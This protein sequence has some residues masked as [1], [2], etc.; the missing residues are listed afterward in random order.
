M[1]GRISSA[2]P[3]QKPLMLEATPLPS[4]VYRRPVIGTIHVEPLEFVDEATG[5]SYT[6][7]GTAY[8][9]I[10]RQEFR[11]GEF[12]YLCNAWNTEERVQL[13]PGFLVER[14]DWR[15]GFAPQEEKR[16]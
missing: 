1:V 6:Y 8:D 2:N 4:E 14:V 3:N 16:G 10:E 12:L 13:V 7:P 15:E 9:I 11:P 5:E